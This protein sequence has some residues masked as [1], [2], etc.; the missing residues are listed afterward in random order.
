MPRST[1]NDIRKA[2]SIRDRSIQKYIKD[3]LRIGV[4]CDH[5]SSGTMVIISLYLEDELICSESF[6][7]E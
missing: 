1:I 2:R 7:P 3:N 6:R 5:D 4:D